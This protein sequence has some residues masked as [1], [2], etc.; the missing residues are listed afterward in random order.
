MGTLLVK[1]LKTGRFLGL[2]LMIFMSMEAFA[3]PDP[4]GCDEG[5]VYMPPGPVEDYP[6]CDP[7]NLIEYCVPAPEV[8]INEGIYVL[9]F[10]GLGYT[11]WLVRDQTRKDSY[12]SK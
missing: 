1:H 8:P 5:E 12:R 10:A 2:I 11:I 4:C 3:Q 6:S 9:V 7:F